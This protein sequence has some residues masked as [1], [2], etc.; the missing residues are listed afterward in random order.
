MFSLGDSLH[1][2][3][4]ALRTYICHQLLRKYAQYLKN[5]VYSEVSDKENCWKD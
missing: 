1:E 3:L 2:A 5:H 4:A